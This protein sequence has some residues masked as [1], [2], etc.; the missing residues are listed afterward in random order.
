MLGGSTNSMELTFEFFANCRSFDVQKLSDS[1]N[2]SMFCLYKLQL[3]IFAA[4]RR[5]QFVNC[6]NQVFLRLIFSYFG[7]SVSI[8]LK[9]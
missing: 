7:S 9:S 4:E 3:H 8:K 1:S 6:G 2:L 5:F